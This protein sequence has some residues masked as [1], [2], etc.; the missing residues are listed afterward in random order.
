MQS[1]NK[2]INS[3]ETGER[4]PFRNTGGYEG[5]DADR[6]R[7]N[8][9]YRELHRTAASQ[10]DRKTH[11][12]QTGR[13]GRHRKDLCVHTGRNQMSQT[14]SM[15]AH[16]LQQ[17]V[18]LAI[19]DSRTRHSRQSHSLQQTVS[20]VIADSLTCYRRQSHSSQKTVSL[21]IADNLTRYSRQAHSLKESLTR[22]HRQTHTGCCIV[23]SGQ[24][25]HKLLQLTVQNR[26]RFLC[27]L[28]KYQYVNQYVQQL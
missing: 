2:C 5:R 27:R 4:S 10:E 18:S 23:Y 21:V 6:R 17:T 7:Q 14:A 20:L 1:R 24:R 19:A 28:P 22:Y 3:K 13:N 15:E 25:T 12:K 8:E 11:R 26:S 16:S 9:C